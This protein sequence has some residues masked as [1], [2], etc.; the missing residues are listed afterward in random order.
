VSRI[1]GVFLSPNSATQDELAKHGL[2]EVAR[3]QTAL[4]YLRRPDVTL[5]RLLSALTAIH[6]TQFAIEDI[7]PRAL[8][9]AEIEA[10]YAAYIEK[11]LAQIERIRDMEDARL[12]PQIEYAGVSGLRNEAREKLAVVQPATLGQASRIPGVTP[13]DLA[14]LVVHLR[15]ERSNSPEPATLALDR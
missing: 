13:G 2:P 10:K 8:S 5:A 1:E 12:G 4:D 15:R 9:C 3:S 11:E 7:N 14:V 6:P